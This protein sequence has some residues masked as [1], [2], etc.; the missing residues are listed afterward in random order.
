M[1]VYSRTYDGTAPGR[2]LD[3]AISMKIYRKLHRLR[4]LSFTAYI[5]HARVYIEKNIHGKTRA[6]IGDGVH[7][8]KYSPS[9]GI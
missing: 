8:T 7:V 9:E 1:H 2:L 3:P 6:K 5:S 4:L